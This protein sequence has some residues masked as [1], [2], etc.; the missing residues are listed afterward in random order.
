[1]KHL[2]LY[3]I[4]F[5]PPKVI[6]P[7]RRLL[8]AAVVFLCGLLALYGVEAWRLGRLRGEVE[9]LLAQADHLE[10]RAQATSAAT[11]ADPKVEAEASGLEAR[12]RNLQLAQ[13][14]LAAGGL[15]SETGYSAQFVALAHAHVAGAWLTRVEIADRGQSLSLAGRA[16]T[17]EDAARLIAALRR[18]PQFAGLSFA[19]M[20]LA[21]PL[22]KPSE[23]EAPPPRYLEFSLDAHAANSADAPP[24][25]GLAAAYSAEA[26]R[27]GVTLSNGNTP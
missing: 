8:V 19:G 26:A 16:L 22:E 10:A 7:A 25:A 6:L 17:G 11:S 1:M 15:G 23:T 13:A 24:A 14:A 21:P 2:N 12:L 9:Q 4:A 27:Q 20:K 3:Q 5:H 18:E